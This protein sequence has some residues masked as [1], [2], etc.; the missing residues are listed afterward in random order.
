MEQFPPDDIVESLY[1]L[2]IG[3]SE[4][5]KDRVGMVQL[6]DP[7]AECET[8]L[9][10]TEDNGKKKVLSKI[11][12][13]GTLGLETGELSQESEGTTSRSQRTRRLLAMTSLRTVFGRRPLAVS[14]TIE[15]SVQKL[16]HTVHSFSWTFDVNTSWE[17]FSE[18][19]KSGGK[20]RISR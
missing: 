2:R 19:E 18:I 9:S 17:E 3:E 1:K 5:L 6:G 11:Q 13:P 14:C 12:D 16:R 10:Q 8:S 7:S 4:K 20:R 15:I